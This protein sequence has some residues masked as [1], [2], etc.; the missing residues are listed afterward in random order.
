MCLWGTA[1]SRIE[2]KISRVGSRTNVSSGED[3]PKI[4][5]KKKTLRKREGRLSRK[6]TSNSHKYKKSRRER[7]RRGGWSSPN[8]VGGMD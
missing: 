8:K 6:Q 2:R 1:S 3:F 5:E 7:L 4:R